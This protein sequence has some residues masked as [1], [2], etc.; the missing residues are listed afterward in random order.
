M[1]K[2]PGFGGMGMGNMGNMQSLIKQAKKMQ[3]QMEEE[4]ANLSTQEFTGKS[5]DDMVVA[6]FTGDRKLKDLQIKPEAIDPDD[7]DMLQDLVIDAINKGIKEVE[8]ATQASMGK[9]TKGLM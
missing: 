5:A 1:S 2:R 4:Q 8:D 3:K 7:P 6:T 9:Y